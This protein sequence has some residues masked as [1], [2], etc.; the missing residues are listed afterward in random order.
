M[1]RGRK[2]ALT[3]DL[4]ADEHK[5][6]TAW[7]QSTTIRAR[8]AKRGRIIL[9][10]AEGVPLVQ[11]AAM[12]GTTRRSVYTWAKRFMHDGLAGLADKR[13][14]GPGRRPEPRRDVSNPV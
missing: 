11:I 1:A 10:L 3:I 5:T 6:L 12:V 13:L 7:Q 9:L 8:R 4:T 2:T 14:G